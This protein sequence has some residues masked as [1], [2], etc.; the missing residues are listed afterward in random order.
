MSG[1][2]F[3]FGLLAV[4]IVFGVVSALVMGRRGHAPFNWLILGAVLGPLVIPVALSRM[5]DARGVS[6]LDPDRAA[7]R[8]PVD[9]LVGMDGSAESLSAAEVVADLLGDRIGRLTLVTVVDYDTALGG[10]AGTTRMSAEEE[11]ASAAAQLGQRLGSD[12]DAV[13]LAGRPAEVLAAHATDSGFDVLAIGSRGRG[14]S[15]L[16]TG[17]VASRLARGASLPVLV[18]TAHHHAGSRTRG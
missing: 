12:V 7:Y 18:V 17:S 1:T 15:R 4:W 5:R 13:V 14:A 16:V 10:T 8:G 3:L 6:L 11:L 9:V 2:A